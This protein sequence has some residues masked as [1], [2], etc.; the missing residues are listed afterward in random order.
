MPKQFE[1]VHPAELLPIDCPCGQTRRA[2][3]NDTD[4]VATCSRYFRSCAA[5][6]SQ[7]PPEVAIVPNVGELA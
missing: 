6:L 7:S 5:S 2:F 3:V 4:G 1:I